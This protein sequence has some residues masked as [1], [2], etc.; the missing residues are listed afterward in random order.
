MHA[1]HRKEEDRSRDHDD[2]GAVAELRHE[3]DDENERGRERTSAVD[4]ALVTQMTRSLL[5]LTGVTKKA[6]PVPNH[7]QLAQRERE[8]DAEDVELNQP[9]HISVE[10]DDQRG[11]DQ[12]QQDDPVR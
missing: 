10:R 8:E 5:A 9:S 4:Q 12:R 6:G 11:R 1:L 3:D 2:P 7:P